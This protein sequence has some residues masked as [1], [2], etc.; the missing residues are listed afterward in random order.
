MTF[1]LL[2]NFSNVHYLSNSLKFC[3]FC[4]WFCLKQKIELLKIRFFWAF[5]LDLCFFFFVLLQLCILL[6]VFLSL[7][8]VI[9]SKLFN[10]FS[11]L[12]FVLFINLFLSRYFLQLDAP[13]LIAFMVTVGSAYSFDILQYL[14]Q[15]ASDTKSK[16]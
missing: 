8:S 2:V 6:S 10:S 1:I 13:W 7:N 15:I 5:F 14:L 9:F 12:F 16:L 11:V 4:S 3:V